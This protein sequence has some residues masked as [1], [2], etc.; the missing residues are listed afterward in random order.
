M[1]ALES[2][3]LEYQA[4]FTKISV[5]VDKLLRDILSCSGARKCIFRQ[6]RVTNF[7]AFLILD[8]AITNISS[9]DFYLLNL[10]MSAVTKKSQAKN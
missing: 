10:G 5:V 6:Y 4:R 1:N 3:F 8:L 2:E 7:H 9:P